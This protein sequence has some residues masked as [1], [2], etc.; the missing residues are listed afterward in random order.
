MPVY[1]GRSVTM[2]GHG[3]NWSVVVYVLKKTADDWDY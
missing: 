3:Y 2:E 1:M